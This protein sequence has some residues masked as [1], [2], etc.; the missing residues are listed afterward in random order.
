[1]SQDNWDRR[2]ERFD[3]NPISSSLGWIIGIVLAIA[4][5]MALVWAIGVGFSGPKGAGDVHKANQ[6]ATNRIQQQAFFEQTKADFDGTLAKLPIAVQASEAAK[7]SKHEAER[8]IEL[9]GLRQHCVDIAADY[10]ARSRE[11][12]TAADWKAVDLP[13]SLDPA[14]CAN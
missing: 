4:V 10:N 9:T 7:G 12:Y 11:T 6:G 8:E 2:A 5:V 1:M 3:R 13:Q 14:L